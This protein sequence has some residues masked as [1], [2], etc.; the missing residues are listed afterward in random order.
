MVTIYPVKPSALNLTRRSP[1]S[2]PLAS[3][4]GKWEM[5]TIAYLLVLACLAMGDVWGP[6][7]YD[8][9]LEI[10]GR[11]E[12][13]VGIDYLDEGLEYLVFHKWLEETDKGFEISVEFVQRC[14]ERSTVRVAE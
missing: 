14:V 4:F 10:A 7:R 5:D 13:R 3:F 11:E 6:V 12:N 1:Y 9:L 8:V 2:F